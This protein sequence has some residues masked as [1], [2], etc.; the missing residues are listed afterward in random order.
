[1]F[2]HKDHQKQLSNI[3]FCLKHEVDAY[4]NEEIV[5]SYLNTYSHCFIFC[6]PLDW[7]SSLGVSW[8]SRSISKV[9]RITWGRTPCNPYCAR[10]FCVCL[11]LRAASWSRL[12]FLPW[13]LF[14][15]TKL[16]QICSLIHLQRYTHKGDFSG[17]V[18]ELD[19]K[20]KMDQY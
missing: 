5:L 19:I 18:P 4:Y 17:F 3:N 2:E 7:C 1:M 13:L 20:S 10:T 8:V 14:F 16:W 15:F 9:F 11:E 6:S 12:H